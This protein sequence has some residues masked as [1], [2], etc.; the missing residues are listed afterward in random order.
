MNLVVLADVVVE[1]LLEYSCS[2][3]TGTIVGKQW[4][5]LPAKHDRADGRP[6]RPLVRYLRTY[7]EHPDPSRIG[8]LTEMLLSETEAA[9]IA[10]AIFWWLP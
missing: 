4:K 1:D 10:L 2:N 9:A 8:I 3:P 5:S 7:V 6:Q